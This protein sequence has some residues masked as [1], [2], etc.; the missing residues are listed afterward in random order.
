MIM[1]FDFY[2][3]VSTDKNRYFMTGVYHDNGVKVATDGRILVKVRQDYSN[4][5]E[6]KIINKKLLPIEG[7]FPKYERVIPDIDKLTPYEWNGKDFIAELKN[8]K[9]VTKMAE[10]CTFKARGEKPP[11]WFYRL[12]NGAIISNYNAE[13]V[14]HFIECFPESKLY[15]N[16]DN[17]KAIVFIYEG[18]GTA[19]NPDAELVVMPMAEHDGL[20]YCGN[21]GFKC[22]EFYNMDRGSILAKYNKLDVL[23]RIE[24]GSATESD[25][26]FLNEVDAFVSFFKM[27]YEK[28][29]A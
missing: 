27:Q 11:M 1:N 2:K 20:A 8:M 10:K 3:F 17:A 28:S 12:P 5:Y 4:I 24:F 22:Y 13:K 29:I 6:G 19:E 15:L 9:K 18:N 7:Q 25:K 21:V 14:L 23:K 16:D 26:A